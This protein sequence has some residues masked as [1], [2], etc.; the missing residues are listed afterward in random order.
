MTVSNR[1]IGRPRGAELNDEEEL[2]RVAIALEAG[3][4]ASRRKAIIS[5]LGDDEPANI[6]RISR[7]YK[8]RERELSAR[9]REAL[10]PRTW[11]GRFISTMKAG[12]IFYH[13]QVINRPH[14]GAVHA[15]LGELHSECRSKL[16]GTMLGYEEL[17]HFS[18]SPTLRMLFG[19]EA[20]G[21]LSGAFSLS[22]EG[23]LTR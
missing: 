13:Y 2:L 11:S 21:V 19:L 22:I 6:A 18:A 23:G 1:V 17:L 9:A 12:L 14:I 20:S 4:A 5:V 15:P 10:A 3:A 7:K 8:M 16:D